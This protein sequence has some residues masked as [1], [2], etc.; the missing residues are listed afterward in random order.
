MGGPVPGVPGILR[1]LPGENLTWPTG[2]S[3]M[4][5]SQAATRMPNSA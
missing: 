5:V 4:T 3:G 1:I 2:E